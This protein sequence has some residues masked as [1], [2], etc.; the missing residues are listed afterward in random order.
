MFGTI[1]CILL[2]GLLLTKIAITL[3]SKN[4]VAS[5]NLQEEYVPVCPDLNFTQSLESILNKPT[6]PRTFVEFYHGF[7]NKRDNISIIFRWNQPKFMNE[8]IQGYIVQCWFIENLEKIKICDDKCISA[9]TLEFTLHNSKPNTTYYFQVRTYTKVGVSPYTDLINVSTTHENA[10]PQLLKISPEHKIFWSNYERDLMILEMNKNNITKIATLKN[11]VTGLCID[12]IARS[13]YWIEGFDPTYVV[14]FDLTMWENGIIKYDEIDLEIYNVANLVIQPFMG[15]LYYTAFDWIH[16]QYEIIQLDLEEKN[17]QHIQ[18]NASD[19]CS[20]PYFDNSKYVHRSIKIDVNANKKVL[21]YWILTKDTESLLIVTDIYAC[22]CNLILNSTIISDNI[23][24]DFLIVDKTNIYISTFYSNR[25]Y[26]LKKRYALLESTENALKYVQMIKVP[27]ITNTDFTPFHIHEFHAFDKSLQSYPPTRCLTPDKN[28]YDIGQIMVATNNISVNL[29]EPIPKSGCKKYNLPAT[30]YTIYISDC[31]DNDTNMFN[32]FI[33]QTYE[34]FYE[35]PNLTPFTEYKLKLAINNFYFDKLSMDPLLS[36]NIMTIKTNLGKLN[37]PENITIHVLTP[38][39]TAVQWMPP[40]KL[41]CV[42]VIYEV[43]WKSFT[44]MNDTQRNGTEVINMPKRTADGKFFTKI[45]ELLPGET[46]WIYVRVYPVNFSNFY[47]DSLSKIVYMYFEP[48]NITL[49]DVSVN[50]LTVSWISNIK[51]AILC[52]LDYTKVAIEKWQIVNN[53][54]VE[55]TEK[56]THYIGNLQPGTIYKFRLKLRYLE[57]EEDFIWPSDER[58]TFSTLG[59]ISSTPEISAKQYYLPLI[60]SLVA[61]VTVICIYYFYYLYR[62]RKEGS[63]Q[64]LSPI[65]TDIELAILHEIPNKNLQINMLYSPMLQYNWNEYVLNKIKREQITLSKLLDSGA[66]G[67]VYQGTVKNLEE[68]GIKT[69]VAIKMLKERASSKEKKEFLQEARLM[70]HFRHKHV[71]K[72]LGVCLDK[73]SALLVLELMETNLL[74]YLRESRTLEPSD[75]HALR[76]QDLLAICEDVARGCCYLQELRFVHRDLAC[77][78]CLVSG[79]NRENRVVKIGDFGLA[80]DVYKDDYYRKEGGGLLPVRWMAPESLATGIFTSK[81]DVWSFG[82]LMWEVTSL[83]EQPYF[84]KTNFEV[85]D[86]VRLGGRLQMPLNC[87]SLLYQLIMRCWSSAN[88]RPK[89]KLCLES[90]IALRNSI[91]D[92]ILNLADIM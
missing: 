51:P 45:Q 29:P 63:E 59:V 36:S 89:F 66:F 24:F 47:N 56:V 6:S 70:N 2:K 16:S 48:N 34:R 69:P 14:K 46:Y 11:I 77:R 43:H 81:S 21:I 61:I 35:I 54:K 15:I 55:N 26:I 53:I 28:D 92:A 12:W 57:Y 68:P 20:C 19:M 39:V 7:M 90:I 31:L 50:S 27:P 4:Y 72:L 79:R 91:E 85:M 74:K 41:N 9:T 8:V 76:L 5:D 62:Q 1:L 86:Y 75:S 83:G 84:D 38:T 88:A 18:K 42:V 73:G 78:N 67:M 17:V 33:V 40:K 22:M 82:V 60:L 32:K 49:D 65:M 3:L 25:V 64:V 80:R 87:P 58:F 13:L 37:A 44:S 30:L 23:S 71:L 52:M 10:I